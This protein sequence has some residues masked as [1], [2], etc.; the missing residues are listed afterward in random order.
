MNDYS[1]MTAVE[2]LDC[3]RIASIKLNKA[4]LKYALHYDDESEEQVIKLEKEF[5]DISEE[6]IKR[7]GLTTA[8]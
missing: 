6:I 3:I 7:M 5:A 8:S 4:D 1:M 2:L